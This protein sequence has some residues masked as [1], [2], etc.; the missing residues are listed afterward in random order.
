VVP[1][2]GLHLNN[3]LGEEDLNPGGFHRHEPGR[4]IPSAMA[5]TVV[6]RDGV[7]EVVL[8]SA[9]SSRIRSA[10][11]QT[12]LRVVADGMPAQEAVEAPRVHYEGRVVEAE[13]GIE[14][15]GLAALE[16]DGWRVQ[17]FRERNLYF[18][19]VQA[20]A[21]DPQT[22]ALSGGGDPRRDGAAIV[23]T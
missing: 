21:R 4:R 17:R 23:V 18:G 9:G 22:G 14:E 2:T 8:G 13:P 3:M 19:G 16:R 7:P 11:L 10:V 6:L 5:P 20:A 1:G 12:V 15:A